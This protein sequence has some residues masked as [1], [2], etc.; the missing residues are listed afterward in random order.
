MSTIEILDKHCLED[1][2]KRF[3]QINSM[4]DTEVD[5]LIENYK[6]RDIE[7]FLMKPPKEDFEKLKNSTIFRHQSSLE[8]LN[9]IILDK[10]RDELSKINLIHKKLEKEQFLRRIEKILKNYT[11][12]FGD[13]IK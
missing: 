5:K 12:K 1:I 8:S 11:R 4:L 7:S 10:F 6:T 2:W 13:D 9:K 3:N